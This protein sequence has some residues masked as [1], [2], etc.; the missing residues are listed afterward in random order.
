MLHLAW[1][2]PR[3]LKNDDPLG[4][5]LWIQPPFDEYRLRQVAAMCR[6]IF[7]KN[8]AN[9]LPYGF[10]LRND[11]FDTQTGEYLMNDSPYG[12]TCA[13]F[14]LA[15]FHV[16]GL[17]LADYA[18]WPRGR[19]DDRTWQQSIVATLSRTPNNQVHVERICK[20]I[21][22]DTVRFHPSEVAASA[23]QAQVPARP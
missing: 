9:G 12:L 16:T 1:H 6:R 23:A 10:G 8:E 11:A 5:Y 4:S 2:G 17:P 22:I 18:T 13:S 3:Q 15:V 7:R 14:V 19:P 20:D 21:G